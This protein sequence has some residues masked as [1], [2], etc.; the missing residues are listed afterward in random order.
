MLYL[1]EYYYNSSIIITIIGIQWYW[2]YN[3][4][5]LKINYNILEWQDVYLYLRSQ[6]R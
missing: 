5:A 1:N 4:P 2:S 3:I 6:Y